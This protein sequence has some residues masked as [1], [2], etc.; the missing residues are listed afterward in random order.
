MVYEELPF[1]KVAREGLIEKMAVQKD[2][3]GIT[4]Q[5]MGV[6]EGRAGAKALR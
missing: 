3:K 5:A 1:Y 2:L 4:E 6:S